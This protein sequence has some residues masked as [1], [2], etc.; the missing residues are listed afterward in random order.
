MNSGGGRCRGAPGRPL[1]QSVCIGL[2]NTVLRRG[3]SLIPR[4]LARV[5]PSFASYRARML[6]GDILVLDLRE[7]MCLGY[8]FDGEIR[9]D[10]AIKH[11]LELMLEE[12]DC[13]LDVGANIGY[14]SRVASRL[15]GKSGSIYAFEPLARAF[16]LLT[17]NSKDCD[18]VVARNIAIGNMDGVTA[19][20]PSQVGDASSVLPNPASEKCEVQVMRLDSLAIDF[21]PRLDV[22]KIDVEGYEL[23]VLEGAKALIE[24]YM[25]VVIY[26]CIPEYLAKTGQSLN[27]YIAFFEGF[28]RAGYS[29]HGIRSG[30]DGTIGLG[31]P[32][33][34]DCCN[35]LALPINCRA[36]GK[37]KALL[38]A[39]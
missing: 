22:I 16:R 33:A 10:H 12:G 19:F 11:F 1:L 2:R 20:Y 21:P 5:F 18:N 26:E 31:P 17:I 37:L 13:F 3:Y 24:K 28:S 4:M 7:T 27:D 29:V 8:F 23:E 39:V 38:E 36:R 25:P 6:D 35:F 15:V 14:Y 30:P 9:Q 34:S 32:L